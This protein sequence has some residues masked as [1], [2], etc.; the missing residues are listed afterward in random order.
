M[1]KLYALV[2][3][4][5]V[6]TFCF[7]QNLTP[8]QAHQFD[9][10]TMKIKEMKMNSAK[11]EAGSMWF[12]YPKLVEEYWGIESDFKGYPLQL[13]TNGLLFPTNG[14]PWHPNVC[15]WAQ[16]YD[17]SNMFYDDV[18]GEGAISLA[19]TS[20]YSL[21]SIMIHGG[22]FRGS[23]T[24]ADAVDTMIVGVLT[25]LSEDQLV[26]LSTSTTHIIDFY[27]VDYDPATG[28]QTNAIIYKFPMTAN[29]VSE[30]EEDGSYYS[31][32]LEYPIGLNNISNK[33][34]HVA[35]AFKRG[36]EAGLND[37]LYNHS[38]FA[39]WIYADPRP[40]YCPYQ[41]G[42]T[43]F[44]DNDNMNQGGVIDS[45][46]RFDIDVAP[47]D[48]SYRIYNPSSFW[49]EL[50]YPYMY[51][52]VS[53]DDCAI[54]GVEEMEK[55]NISVYPNPATNNF[56]VKLNGDETAHIQLFNLVGQQVYSETAANTTTINVSNM[57]SG[58]YMLKVSQNGKV[59]TSKVIV[60]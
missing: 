34:L 12:T 28:V 20:T 47:D 40:N 43:E 38:Y 9:G 36:Y 13:D 35:Y 6:A 41:N 11:N 56:T 19:N 58:I 46:T 5:L 14:T 52:K 24:P 45:D 23:Q 7:A 50:H 15:G 4:M 59:Y 18:L 21:D 54:V 60:K 17:F 29:D 25:T 32:A 44:I 42:W 27:A 3:L 48:W 10:K 51:I 2:A 53:C 39:A 37:T 57:K 30:E 22:Y 1:K 8:K 49:N 31:A 55:E 26:T 33:V 16:T